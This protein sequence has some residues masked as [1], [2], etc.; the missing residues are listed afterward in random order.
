M[1]GFR[2]LSGAGAAALDVD[3]DQGDLRHDREADGLLLERETGPR[4]DRDGALARVRRAD[5]EGARRDLVLGLMHDA[6]D[7]L[8]DLAQVV[9]RR[10]RWRD[11][12]HRADLHTRRE[13][14]EGEC[15][16]P[17]HDDLGLG[18]ADRGDAVPEVEVRIGPRRAGLEQLDVRRDDFLVLL[19][20]RD[21]DLLA[22]EPQLEAVDAAEH[23][24]HE[25]VLA[26]ARIRDQLPALALH[27]DLDDAITVGDES[28]V[29]FQVGARDGRVAVLAPHRFEQDRAA[30]FQLARAD[31]PEEDLLV[32]RHD[33]IDLVPAIRDRARA[34]AH[35]VAAR[36]R[37]AA[38][39]WLDLCRDDLDGPDAVA[40]F[41]RDRGERLAASLR[42]LTGVAD[43]LDDVLADRRGHTS[44]SR[45]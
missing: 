14:P 30:L 21:G 37:D 42:A 28:L 23:P 7:P 38:C 10:C 8:E 31:A 24:Q 27:R 19:A 16:V 17:V 12:V 13:D 18:R 1:L 11:R 20:E 36:A 39:R 40:G 33:E 3:D 29:R 35:A 41:G 6:T 22:R 2:R 32:E 15:A 34:E 45:A 5:R 44:T 26:L 4:R 43:D 9:G 25:H